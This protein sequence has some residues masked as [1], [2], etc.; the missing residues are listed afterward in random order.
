MVWNAEVFRPRPISNGMKR[1]E[2]IVIVFAILF[3]GFLFSRDSLARLAWQK[4][5]RADLAITLDRTDAGLAMLIGNRYFGN[6]AYDLKI[7]ERAYRKAVKINP[8]ILWGHYQLA[9][10]LFVNPVTASS[11]GVKGNYDGAIAEINKE[12]ETNPENLRSLYVRGLIYG[13]RNQTGDLERA[14]DDFRR[15]TAW[16]PSEWAG[17]NDLAWIL[18]KNG[19]YKE[20]KEATVRAFQNAEGAGENPW[21]WNSQGVAEL[22]LGEYKNAIKSF[23]KAKMLAEKLALEDWRKSYPGN[24]PASAG[25]GLNQFKETLDKNLKRA[26][27][28]GAI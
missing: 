23:E 22:N 16:A 17:Y 2:I 24:D 13:Y 20:A 19:K 26:E 6:G 1:W 18:S 21:L 3:F 4:Y 28:L 14:A 12:L 15:F 10:I 9:R 25:A 7:A 11:N 8:K 5:G 27:A